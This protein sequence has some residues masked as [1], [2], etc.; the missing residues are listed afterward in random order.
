MLFFNARREIKSKGA[1]VLLYKE[2]AFGSHVVTDTSPLFCGRGGARLPGSGKS[3][4]A[5]KIAHISDFP[6]VKLI[7]PDKLVGLT[8]SHKIA[9][10][11]KV[12]ENAYKSTRSVVIIDDVERLIDFVEI[13]AG[14]NITQFCIPGWSVPRTLNF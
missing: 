14:A 2:G 8:V 9:R 4:L 6:F 5:R 3:S 10:I 7:T 11:K 12:F 1:R 13:G